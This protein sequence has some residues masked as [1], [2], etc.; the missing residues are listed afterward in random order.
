MTSR[1][2]L[3]RLGLG[4]AWLLSLAGITVAGF[5]VH[6]AVTGKRQLE[7][8][9]ADLRARGEPL[10][11][12]DLGIQPGELV[13]EEFRAIEKTIR[14]LDPEAFHHFDTKDLNRLIA[15][16]ATK[17]T[18][19]PKDDPSKALKNRLNIGRLSA[20][21]LRHPITRKAYPFEGLDTNS[22]PALTWPEA[23]TSLQPIA[24]KFD[25]LNPAILRREPLY[26]PGY[27][28]GTLTQCRGQGP[29]QEYGR[30][31]RALAVLD[32]K[33]GRIDSFLDRLKIRRALTPSLLGDA[34]LIEFLVAVSMDSSVI[35]LGW[36]FLQSEH[37]SKDTL[38]RLQEIVGTP[39][40]FCRASEVFRSERVALLTTL[41]L[42]RLGG[43]TAREACRKAT[44][45]SAVTTTFWVAFLRLHLL[46][47]SISQVLY[48]TQ[49]LIATSRDLADGKPYLPVQERLLLQRVE[50]ERQHPLM[51]ML[52]R[53]Q[54]TMIAGYQVILET[55][56]FAEINHRQLLIAI[57]LK[58]YELEHGSLP[59][60][61]AMLVP[62]HVSKIPADPMDGKPMRYRKTG[63]NS[64]LLYSVG[65]NGTD[66]RGDPTPSLFL[67]KSPR[68]GKDILWPMPA[69]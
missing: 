16:L 35:S 8:A 55:A 40:Y 22:L 17:R 47:A 60:S 52:Q 65:Y 59:D 53:P 19:T 41:S 7:A 1:T 23:D 64:S 33:N 27:A 44:G 39:D 12:E 9:I 3:K 57:A 6:H 46:D 21:G 36:E 63:E 15:G 50:F 5:A 37:T 11:I 13:T 48:R 14:D 51:R 45:W 61:I 56:A 30:W 69:P 66:D 24:R 67:S 25:A 62:R 38:R 2:W 42:L 31:L 34:L 68:D 26:R 28:K 4:L 10:C 49:E 32:L 18:D 58:Q 20:P 54:T 29:A 43:P